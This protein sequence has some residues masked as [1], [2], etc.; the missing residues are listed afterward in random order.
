MTFN[1]P[2]AIRVTAKQI[3]RYEGYPNTSIQ[4]KPLLIYHQAFDATKPEL[5][6]RLADMGA[7]RPTWTNTMYSYSHFHSTAHEVLGVISGRAQLCFGGEDSPDR[8][9]VVVQK[10][11]LMIVP[12]GVSHRLLEDYGGDFDLLG[13]YPPGSTYDMC[14]GGPREE[15]RVKGIAGLPW[16]DLDPLYGKEG[17]ALHV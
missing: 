6:K 5:E 2:N 10:G 3:P 7:V 9:E 14:Y 8:Y 13:A 11:D 16:F 12:A 4:S 17:P 15:E 1:P